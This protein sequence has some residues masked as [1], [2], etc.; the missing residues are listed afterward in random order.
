[1]VQSPVV[2]SRL[3]IVTD[4]LMNGNYTVPRPIASLDDPGLTYPINNVEAD[5]VQYDSDSATIAL[6][7]N[8]F[9]FVAY[10]HRVDGGAWSPLAVNDG[11]FVWAF[12]T[13]STIEIRGV[14]V[15]GAHSPDVVIRAYEFD[16]EMIAPCTFGPQAD[17][18][19]ACL[20]DLDLDS[21]GDVDLHDY[22]II[23]QLY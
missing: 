14:G 9:D 12:G 3:N 6:K 15:S 17:T 19:S 13:S 11:E 23:M 8:M 2:G 22:S 7:N 10:E 21:D 18:L 20:P 16:E 1:M 4:D 5:I